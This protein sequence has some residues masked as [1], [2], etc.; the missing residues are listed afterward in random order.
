MV[1]AQAVA[2]PPAAARSSTKAVRRLEDLLALHAQRGQFV[3]VEEAPVVDLV[4]CDAP[5]GE[6]VGLRLDQRVQR[7]AA[8]RE[9]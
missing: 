1:D 4:G 2:T 8:R 3:D 6:A 9:C 5:V 7:V